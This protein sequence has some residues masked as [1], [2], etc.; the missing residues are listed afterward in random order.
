MTPIPNYLNYS[1]LTDDM[2]G[3]TCDCPLCMGIA[4]EEYEDDTAID[5][6]QRERLIEIAE[7]CEDIVAEDEEAYDVAEII[8]VLNDGTW[9]SSLDE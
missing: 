6:Y 5:A 2:D 8:I 3:L 9:V 4:N 1:A 7:A